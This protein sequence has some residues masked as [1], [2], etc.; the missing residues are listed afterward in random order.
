MNTKGFTLLELL[1]AVAIFSI[2]GV[3]AMKAASEHVRAVT[4]LE[5]RTYASYVAE[6]QLHAVQLEKTWPLKNESKTVEFANRT[7]LWQQQIR[8]TA[9]SN[10]SAV[11]VQVSL[12]EEPNRVIVELQTYLGKPDA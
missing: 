8:K 7:W 2:A 4:M 1:I 6:N 3:A 11:V 10:F 12:A 9:D 5:E